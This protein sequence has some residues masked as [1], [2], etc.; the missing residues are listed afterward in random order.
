MI[1]CCSCS[2]L[3]VGNIGRLHDVITDVAVLLL[4]TSRIENLSAVFF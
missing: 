1:R 4:A 2:L 3:G